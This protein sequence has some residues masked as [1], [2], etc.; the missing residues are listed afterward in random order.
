MNLFMNKIAPVCEVEI[1]DKAKVRATKSKLPGINETMQIA[2]IFKILGDPT[3]LKIILAL[4][5][6][7]LCVCDLSAVA[8]ASVSA[9]SHQLRLLR[10]VKLVKYRKENKMVYYN[11]DD[12]HIKNLVDQLKEH[13]NE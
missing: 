2:E 12:D 4:I 5:E 8:G 1:I 9:V 11:I 6:N 7:E 13:V 3:R 10:N